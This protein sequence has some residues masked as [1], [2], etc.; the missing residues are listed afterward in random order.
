[1]R[2]A[3]GK[4]LKNAGYQKEMRGVE[5]RRRRAGTGSPRYGD[6]ARGVA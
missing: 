1:M 5:P 2:A 4:V 6:A 3:D